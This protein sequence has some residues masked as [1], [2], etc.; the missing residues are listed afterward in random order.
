[1]NT[2]PRKLVLL[3]AMVAVSAMLP[4]LALA[5][6]DAVPISKTQ[7]AS[8]ATMLTDEASQGD[9]GNGQS[10]AAGAR[11]AD[12]APYIL[13]AEEIITLA[14][15]NGYDLRIAEKEAESAWFEYLKY[16]GMA[17]GSLD[18]VGALKRMGPVSKT[19]PITQEETVLNLTTQFSYPLTPLG[20]F[21]YGKLAAKSGYQA[22][23][24]Q[25]N[26]VRA[27][28]I[29]KAFAAYV[30]YL[31]ALNGLKVAEEGIAL[32]EEQLKNAR[33]KFDN[34]VAPRFE[35]IQ[36]EV[37]MSQAREDFINANNGVELA[38]SAL[39]YTIGIT[40]E[41]RFQNTEVEV[42][43]AVALDRAVKYISEGIYPKLDA[44]S[45][46]ES[47]V[48]KTPQFSA[49][50][51]KIGMYHYQALANRR[52]PYFSLDAG[53][54]LQKGITMSPENSWS[55]GI[56]GKF[57][58][59]DSETTESKQRSFTAQANGARLELE[60]YKQGFRLGIA[61]ALST[62]EASIDGYQ[63]AVNTLAQA[64]EG[65][66]MARIG[67]KEGVVTHAD[68]VGARTAFLGAELNEFSKRMAVVTGYQALLSL[69]G[70]GD[71]TLYL[72]TTTSDI[73]GIVSEVI[74]N[75]EN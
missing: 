49:L 3:L 61:N 22:R 13:T 21:S 68:L 32:A 69:L 27:Q 35:V 55:F 33:F 26:M 6:D 59:W 53:Y 41:E 56:S 36:G 64:E 5:A 72:P 73:S 66:R 51:G 75:E 7:P 71:E 43:Y 8:Q 62:L 15:D 19:P 50:Q 9:D 16:V 11:A 23:L 14:L 44:A 17:G 18:L 40:P 12:A 2:N 47:Y 52:A 45:L 28:T 74:G 38:Y 24:S 67:Y 30:A 46:Y 58:L 25:V 54:T 34:D 4:L 42:E 10:D 1:M 29:S 70:V 31:T 39:Y 60:Q 65:L 48:E 57:N 37:A 20:N 63:T